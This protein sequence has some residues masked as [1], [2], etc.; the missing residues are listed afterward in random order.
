MERTLDQFYLLPQKTR[1][2]LEKA[3]IKTRKELLNRGA[4]THDRSKLLKRLELTE[5]D[6]RPWLIACDLCR[7]EGIL[8]KEA[9]K[10]A[11]SG[12][13]SSAREFQLLKDEQLE[14]WLN[15]RSGYSDSDVRQIRHHAERIMPLVI[16]DDQDV[17]RYEE[18]TTAYALN[19]RAKNLRDL[20]GVGLALIFSF[21]L[22]VLLR[23]LALWELFQS[24]NMSPPLAPLIAVLDGA[25][26]FFFFVSG[27]SGF[28]LLYLCSYIAALL[29]AYFIAWFNIFIKTRIRNK[30]YRKIDL[31]SNF[32][33]EPIMRTGRIV[34]IGIFLMYLVTTFLFIYDDQTPTPYKIVSI[35]VPI[36]TV[37]GAVAVGIV[38]GY[39]LI[40]KINKLQDKRYLYGLPILF[41]FRLA[42]AMLIPILF[43]A[44]FIAMTATLNLHRF[45]IVDPLAGVY[46]DWL[47][48][49]NFIRNALTESE[50]FSFSMDVSL[51][52]E[53]ARLKIVKS[54]DLFPTSYWNDYIYPI[55]LSICIWASIA[56]S[57]LAT[58]VIPLLTKDRKKIILIISVTF[59]AFLLERLL[60]Q[61]TIN[62]LNLPTN[63]FL[64]I[65]LIVFNM[66]MSSS[67]SD[68][69][70]EIN[71]KAGSI[72]CPACGEILGSAAKYCSTCGTAITATAGKR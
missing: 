39:Y 14:K 52:F 1:V 13:V 41:S 8:P 62:T 15:A 43:G 10:I 21:L 33:T 35:L 16:W 60:D 23:L 22:F 50:N 11:L 65:I 63:S 3:K 32:D 46:L 42:Q 28:F 55:F 72:Q 40:L 70:E 53:H 68:L 44:A 19:N 67:A 36:I 2:V 38:E 27:A 9:Q 34:L 47:H 37:T 18:I 7:I 4:W 48:Q 56:Y 71:E 25:S 57:F 69:V 54:L 20:K 64:A 61:I 59:G 30:L 12:L 49:W 29:F 58:I 31:H 24:S 6:L 26:W 5:A 66:L 17:S 51:L 45:L